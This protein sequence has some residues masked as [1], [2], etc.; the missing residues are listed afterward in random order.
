MVFVVFGLPFPQKNIRSAWQFPTCN[1]CYRYIVWSKINCITFQEGHVITLLSEASPLKC[2]F[3]IWIYRFCQMSSCLIFLRLIFDFRQLYG[4]K[5][6]L[7]ANCWQKW[8]KSA[9]SM[10][11]L[12]FLQETCLL[13]WFCLVFRLIIGW[14]YK[15]RR[16]FTARNETTS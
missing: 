16:L 1:L 14:I 11:T 2:M 13:G 6:I 12:A 3:Y 15:K 5:S 7:L 10:L 8:S 4:L 9:N